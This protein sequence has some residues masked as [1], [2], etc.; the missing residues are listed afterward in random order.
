[1]SA[2]IGDQ[3][4]YAIYTK[5]KCE[6]QVCQ[7]LT[8]KGIESYL[9]L[10]EKVKRYTRKIKKYQIPL[11][12]CY[13]FVRIDRSSTGKVL[14][15][16]NVRKFI[17]PGKEL[18]AV[19]EAEIDILRRVTGQSDIAIEIQENRLLVE[20]DTVEIIQGSLTGLRGTLVKLENKKTVVI[21]LT[22]VGYQL[23]IT[24]ETK[25]LKKV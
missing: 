23:L 24:I 14:Q 12:N 7:D 11:I 8:R 18:V 5:Y 4:W 3:N 10:L 6:K 22:T 15:T 16:E 9:P 1:M 19:S 2:T 13:V 20:G 21:D 17:K 25:S